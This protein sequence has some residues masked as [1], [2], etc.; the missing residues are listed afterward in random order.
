MRGRRFDLRIAP[1]R[2]SLSPHPALSPEYK[3][4]GSKRDFVQGGCA[5]V[6][7]PTTSRSWWAVPT[8]QNPVYFAGGA[9]MYAATHSK[10]AG[11]FGMD[12]WPPE[13]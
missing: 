13:C 4:E 2:D 11:K 3:G 12:V 7:S 1:Y 8:L 5:R 6:Y 10:N 9:G